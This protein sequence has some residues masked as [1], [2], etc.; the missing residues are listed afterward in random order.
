MLPRLIAIG[1]GVLGLA[2][3]SLAADLPG[4][5]AIDPT[6][7]IKTQVPRVVPNS[8]RL[9][10]KP[11]SRDLTEWPSLGYQ[12]KRPTP[13]PQVTRLEGPS[14]GDV[15]RGLGI[16]MDP[17][18]GN[19]VACHQLPGDAWPGTVGNPLL[20][21]RRYGHQDAQVYQ[22]IFDARVFNPN[23][24]MPAY[25]TFGILS[26]QDVRDLVAFLQSLD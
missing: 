11:H 26:D 18:R 6:A 23:S 8:G 7:A 13:K 9:Q 21:Y 15:A 17:A 19:C 1:W 10:W 5:L 3:C 24:V 4:N 25:G 22:Q 2:V 16:A 14:N 12:D 20:H